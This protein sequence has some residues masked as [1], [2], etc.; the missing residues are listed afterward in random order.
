MGAEG[1]LSTDLGSVDVVSIF[2]TGPKSLQSPQVTDP[3][4]VLTAAGLQDAGSGRTLS[5][6]SEPLG[7]L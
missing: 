4:Q 1:A 2:S 3:P 6:S 5:P 7:S